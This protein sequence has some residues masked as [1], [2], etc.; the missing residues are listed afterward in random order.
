MLDWAKAIHEAI[1]IDSPR[2]FIAVF[3]VVGLLVFG[4]LGWI[5]D[6]GYRVKLREQAVRPAS[7]SSALPASAAP[8]PV[9]G[10][11][12][13]NALANRK[14]T[15][16]GRRSIHQSSTGPNSPNLVTGDNSKVEIKQE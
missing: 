9:V 7:V 4:A 15:D 6:K 14:S 1:G 13:G 12:T 10:E 5:V 11:G 3:A 16:Y 2:S 8:P